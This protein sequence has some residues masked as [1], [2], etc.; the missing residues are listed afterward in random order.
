M[1]NYSINKYQ[2]SN[3]QSILEQKV[4]LLLSPIASFIN[5]QTTPAILLFAASVLSLLIINLS[6]EHL[7]DNL[8][9][10]RI[11]LH[12]PE[13]DYIMPLKEWINC[14]LMTIFFF[15]IGLEVK[16]EAIAGKLHNI[17]ELT[18]ILLS[19]FGGML[20]P[21]LIYY[22]INYFFYTSL[23]AN[24]INNLGLNGWV[25][26]TATDTAFA[27]GVLAIFSRFLSIN[28]TIFLTALVVFDDIGSMIICAFISE[29]VYIGPLVKG[30]LVFFL[31]LSVNKSGIRSGLIFTILG[32]VLWYYIHESGLHASLAGLL[33]AATIPVKPYISHK[34]Y[35]RT[36]KKI[37]KQ[38][39]NN[40]DHK[41][42]EQLTTE[43]NN[44]TYQYSS[45]LQLWERKLALPI[46]ICVL[47]LF[48][49]FNAGF[50]VSANNIYNAL[51][52]S[53]TWG[54][55]LGL[56]IGKPLGIIL[57]SVFAYKLKI[58]KLPEG[59][60]LKEIT[61]IGLLAGIGFTMAM[62][63]AEFIYG[64]Q[65][66]IVMLAK[67]GILIASVLSTIIALAWLYSIRKVQS[68]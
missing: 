15:I 60:T 36:I 41:K 57:F 46:C 3:H 17:K 2:D 58:G 50:I 4:N 65:P 34:K 59:L 20:I 68:T 38:L 37:S 40:C 63:H 13:V 52:S 7:L 39:K 30:I 6:A 33:I 21:A 61:G 8:A 24:N 23:D 66:E 25:I 28:I 43:I 67:S 12:F 18:L 54:I 11:G 44:I 48:A 32:I 29:H 14:G 49:F 22:V 55:I 5:K 45:P 53:V 64:N 19:A 47:P 10:S 56:V 62:Y 42:R 16:R 27:I 26:P 35:I 9:A 31:L 51:H 1:N